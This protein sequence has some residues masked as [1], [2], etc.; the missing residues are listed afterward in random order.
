MKRTCSFD[1]ID[2]WLVF[3]NTQSGACIA[4][5]CLLQAGVYGLPVGGTG[6]SGCTWLLVFLSSRDLFL[7]LC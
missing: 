7:S 6:M 4:N 1:V 3:N 5:D 2:L